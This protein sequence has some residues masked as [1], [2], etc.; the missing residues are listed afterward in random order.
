MYQNYSHLRRFFDATTLINSALSD[1]DGVGAVV[2]VDL[3]KKWPAEVKRRPIDTPEVDEV[4]DG[5]YGG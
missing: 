5:L 4:C 3:A 1:G 2:I